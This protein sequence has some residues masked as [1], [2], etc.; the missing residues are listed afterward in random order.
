MKKTLGDILPDK[1]LT[2][3]GYLSQFMAEK[4]NHDLGDRHNRYILDCVN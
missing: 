1:S 2:V 4:K 3:C